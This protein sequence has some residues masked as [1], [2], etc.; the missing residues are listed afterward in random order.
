MQVQQFTSLSE[1]LSSPSE[2]QL[3]EF[4]QRSKNR[5]NFQINAPRNG[6]I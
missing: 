4:H 2:R 5:I 6:S 1:E 3:K